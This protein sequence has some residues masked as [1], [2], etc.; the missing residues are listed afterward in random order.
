MNNGPSLLVV[1]GETSGDLHAGRLLAALYQRMPEISAF[2]M[3]GAELA[4]AGLECLA[5]SEDIAVVGITE[6]LRVLP[7]ARTIF[8]TLLAEVD[9]RQ[10]R[11]ALL[12][13]A[14]DFNLRLAKALRRRGV[15]VIYYISPQVWAWRKRRAHAIRR[16]VD[17]MLVL[18]G[19]EVDFYRRYDVDAVHVGHPLVDEVP[20][21]ASVWD[22]MPA[23]AVPSPAIISLL[24]GSR[25]SEVSALLPTLLETV[26]RLSALRSLEVRLI[27]A[28][29]LTQDSFAPALAKC[30][31]AVE[32]VGSQNRFEAIAG[33]H[34]ALC[35]SGTATLEVALLR[36]PMIVVYRL[37]RWSYLLARLLVRLPSFSLVNLVLEQS[38]VPERLQAATEPQALAAEAA[39]LLGE[40]ARI[41]TMRTDLEGVRRRLGASGASVRAAEQVADLLRGG[42]G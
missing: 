35:A 37:A 31:L 32:V 40:R 16:T 18:F 19:F 41:D 2:G 12:V 4:A 8:H 13:D 14:P 6:A 20:E 29:T 10:T 33:S 34:L 27:R 39:V 15:T 17:R 23:G 38:A 3:G 36:T 7:R 1:A 30:R 22:A 5:S 25:A 11:F 21:R 24:P 42:C 9:R 28:P 26:E